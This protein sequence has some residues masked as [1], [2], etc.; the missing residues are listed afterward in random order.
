MIRETLIDLNCGRPFGLRTHSKLHLLVLYQITL[1]L[2]SNV[3]IDF[4][5]DFVNLNF[6]RY[7]F[8]LQFCFLL[9]L[10]LLLLLCKGLS[11]F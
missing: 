4:L 5:V 3:R 10:R 9:L 7:K 11:L 8:L 6:G 2:L 1:F